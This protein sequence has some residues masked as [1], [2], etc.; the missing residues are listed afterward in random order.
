MEKK[1]LRFS[2]LVSV[3]VGWLSLSIVVQGEKIPLSENNSDKLL[4]QGLQDTEEAERQD[5][6]LKHAE[7]E[8]TR[9]IAMEEPPPGRHE[10]Q[11]EAD[12]KTG[13]APEGQ[14][15]AEE[16]SG[17]DGM[18]SVPAGE[19]SMGC[20]EQVDSECEDDEK[21]Q[22]Q[23]N[24]PGFRIDKTEVTVEAY[25]QCVNAKHCTLPDTGGRGSCNWELG[26]REKYPI[27]CIDWKQAEAFCVWAGKRLP[28]DA[29]WEKAARGTDGRVYPS[30]NT[31][32]IT[33]GNV[34]ESYDGYQDTAPVGSFPAGASPY[35]ALDM[36]GN[37]WEWTADWYRNG[38]TR[39]LR[40]GSWV[41]L[42]RRARSSRRIGTVP[43]SRLDDVGVR[44]AQ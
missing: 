32:D 24:V 10:A 37:V 35:G 31:W 14:P 2:F 22:R 8:E 12:P 21:P 3:V 40:G 7:K 39:S 15:P 18:V 4:Q 26:G 29:E 1:T 27:N 5:A 43:I 28:T 23:V 34:Y 25:R 36:A 33:T 30:G 41:D 38:E 17:K 6:A 44:C 16:Q 9:K 20:N 42:P 19:F 11:A 13:V